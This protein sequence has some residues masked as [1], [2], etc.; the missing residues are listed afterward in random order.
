MDTLP[1]DLQN[2]IREY[3]LP[4]KN[5]LILQKKKVVK[6][7]D[8]L[9]WIAMYGPLYKKNNSISHMLRNFYEFRGTPRFNK[10]VIVLRHF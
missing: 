6:A 9:R 4:D 7:I 2:I 1:K 5:M 3:T 10:N 8:E